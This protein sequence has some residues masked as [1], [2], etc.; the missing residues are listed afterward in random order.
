MPEPGASD[1]TVVA[2]YDLGG[3]GPPL[4]L[5]H[6]T[7]FHGRVWGPLV[8]G[9]AERF[10]C[11][12]FDQRGHG[13]TPA[14]ADG[15]F[16]WRGLAHDALAVVD[17]AGLDRPFGFGH[18]AGATALLLAEAARPGAFRAL[19]CYEP[20]VFPPDA[21]TRGRHASAAQ[22]LAAAARRR[23]EVF[24]SRQEAYEHFAGKPPFSSLHPAA[25][26]A[27]VDHG[28]DD[29]DD[30][31]VRLKCRAESEARTYEMGGRHD[32]WDRMT[33][34]ACPVTV[35]CGARSDSF[36][37]A[38]TALQVS[39]LAT[40]RTEVFAELGHFGPLQ[41]PPAVASAVCRSLLRLS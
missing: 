16:D 24:H 33:G 35:A 8:E 20:V 7:G 40:G 29:L 6:A 15:D 41:D 3:S 17:A 19:Y 10:R 34:I 22:T 4:L 27:F 2:F 12:S 11:A 39:R 18:S 13:D 36:G 32:A 9:L 30:G 37:P 14:P 5:A 23:R 26:R 21:E 38:L 28:F 25:L 31:R 1:A